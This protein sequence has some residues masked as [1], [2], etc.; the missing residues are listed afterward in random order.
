MSLLTRRMATQQNDK[1]AQ[2]RAYE[3]L[4]VADKNAVKTLNEKLQQKRS[5]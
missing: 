4:K 2:L 5:K 3:I 1:I